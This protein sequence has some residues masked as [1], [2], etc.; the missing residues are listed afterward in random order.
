MN[1]QN[2]TLFIV[3]E[4]DMS[5]ENI[6]KLRESSE[7]ELS[8]FITQKLAYLHNNLLKGNITLLQ[9]HKE[10]CNLKID[11]DSAFSIIEGYTFLILDK[12]ELTVTKDLNSIEE[13]NNG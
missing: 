7:K 4:C 11:F 6:K 10:F 9:A 2:R 13:I 5:I 12:E 3:K 1:V 8:I